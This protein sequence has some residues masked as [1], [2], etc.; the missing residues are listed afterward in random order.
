MHQNEVQVHHFVSCIVPPTLGGIENKSSCMPKL[1]YF[2]LLVPYWYPTT[3][4][5]AMAS[6]TCFTIPV[7][8]STFTVIMSRT[9]LF[10]DWG[11]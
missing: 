4:N 8:S 7:L 2:Q 6:A 1:V 5:F 9:Y 11:V 10:W 3:P